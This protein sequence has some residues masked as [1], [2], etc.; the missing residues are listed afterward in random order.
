M[1][2]CVCVCVYEMFKI[3]S[4]RIYTMIPDLLKK[5]NLLHIYY[6]QMLSMYNMW[7]ENEPTY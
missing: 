4:N 2:V 5:I 6:T 7:E 3:L 1:C